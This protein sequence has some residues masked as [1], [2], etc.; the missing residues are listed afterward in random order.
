MLKHNSLNNSKNFSKEK[1]KAK[2]SGSYNHIWR[3]IIY[4]LEWHAIN[5]T[6]HSSLWELYQ[7]TWS[8]MNEE[9]QIHNT[10]CP[11]SHYNPGGISVHRSFHKPQIALTNTNR[12][13]QLNNYPIF[14]TQIIAIHIT[15]NFIF[16]Y[17][18]P[19]IIVYKFKEFIQNPK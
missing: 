11:T 10:R 4:G 6:S 7:H 18:R 17:P 9:M 15:S 1:K 13:S 3:H 12:N 5:M 2:N 14:F 16:R 8:S 19:L